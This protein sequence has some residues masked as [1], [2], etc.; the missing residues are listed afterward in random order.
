M[1]NRQGSGL[2]SRKKGQEKNKQGSEGTGESRQESEKCR[3]ELV[4]GWIKNIRAPVREPDRLKTG[5][6]THSAEGWNA[7][8]PLVLFDNS[9]DIVREMT[10]VLRKPEELF[11]LIFEKL[12]L[13]LLPYQGIPHSLQEDRGPD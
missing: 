12:N 8:I 11:E 6:L 3:K 9:Q 10:R 2:C 1:V 13:G 4:E 7:I 5:V